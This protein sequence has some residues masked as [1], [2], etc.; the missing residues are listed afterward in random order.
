M[1]PPAGDVPVFAA[2]ADP[3]RRRLVIDLAAKSPRT[4]TQLARTYPITRQGVLKH[5]HILQDAGL[6]A[7]SRHGRE[8]RFTLVP[9]PLDDAIRWNSEM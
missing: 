1:L 6:V 3:T 2:L 7:T 5:L 4:A 9:E 8:A